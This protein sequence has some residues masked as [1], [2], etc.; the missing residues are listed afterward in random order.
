MRLPGLYTLFLLC[1]AG[2]FMHAQYL[3]TLKSAFTGRKSLDVGFDSR[4]S[5]VNHERMGIH[6]LK[7]GVNFGKK[8]ACGLGY[9][10]LSKRTPVE[11]TFNFYDLDLKKDIQLTRRLF[12][13][14][15]RCYVNYIYYR[16]RRW[17]FSI[18]IQF[19]IGKQGFN[20]TYQEVEYTS[21]KSICLLYEPEVD[22]KFKMLRWLGAEADIGYRFMVNGSNRF[23][24][25]KFNSPLVSVGLFVVWNE[26]ALIAFPKDEKV[27]KKFGP[28]QW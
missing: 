10:W 25:N 14:Y 11:E 22:V 5:F 13:S 15:V 6:S 7:L 28:S 12:F 17:E 18:P 1:L 20:Y 23:I 8:I 3:D 2:H 21:G 19:G 9:A 26:L 4:N 27:Q 16:S 24:K